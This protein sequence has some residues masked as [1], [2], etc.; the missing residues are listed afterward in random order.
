MP[1]PGYVYLLASRRDGTLYVGV[2]SDLA[3]R[4]WEHQHLQ[5]RESFTS[6]YGVDR[7]VYYEP[8]RDIRDA[9][10]RE[11]QLKKWKRSW[12]PRLIEETNPKWKDL[13]VELGLLP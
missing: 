1:K 10:S 11:K 6:R 13:A 2:T 5:N 9:I 7:L 12:K 3:K 8:H 4:I